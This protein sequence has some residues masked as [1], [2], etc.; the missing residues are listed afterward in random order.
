M[1]L[2]TKIKLSDTNGYYGTPFRHWIIKSLPKLIKKYCPNRGAKILDLGCGQGQYAEVIKKLNLE[3]EYL[4]IDIQSRE[5]WN[6]IT[7]KDELKINFMA[8]DAEKLSLINK[9]YNFLFAITSF[10]HFKNQES[11]INGAYQ[12]TNNN[13]KILIIIPSHY[14][15]LNYWTHGYR[16]YSNYSLKKLVEDA[17]YI[18]IKIGKIGGIFSFCFHFLWA[19]ISR[20]IQKVLKLIVFLCFLGNMKKA[21]E[22]LPTLLKLLDNIMFLH[23]KLKLGKII[24]KFFI[25]TTNK[26]DKWVPIF[27][28]GYYC[29]AK[30]K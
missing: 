19:N 30:K 23:L 22:K 5:N 13:G 21:R 3:G 15:Y 8:H 11:V 28:I 7:S 27:E 24:H 1:R 6:N 2:E 4:G 10:E 25:I 9:N 18:D 20:L 29:I 14:S 26:L 12:I 16:R 17:G